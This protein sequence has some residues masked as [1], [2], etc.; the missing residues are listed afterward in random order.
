MRKIATFVYGLFAY[1]LFLGIF[2]YAIGFVGN[3]AV[4]KSID[5]GATG[6]LGAAIAINVALLGLFGLQHS[7][8]ARPGFKKWWTKIVPGAVERSTFVLFTCL[9]LALLYWQWRPI[10]QPVWEVENTVAWW[11]LQVIQLVGWGVVLLS[12]AMIHHFD[13]FG[14]RQVYLYLRGEQYQHL[15]FRTPGLYRYLRHPI[16][17]GFL[18]A[19]WVTPVM[20]AGHLLFAVVT[21]AY[22][23]V[24]LQLEEHD[25]LK[26]HGAQYEQYRRQ[27][28]MLFPGRRRAVEPAPAPARQV[29]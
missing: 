29:A 7:V 21:T 14:M 27:V 2:L 6:P 17:L 8:M 11:I 24:A 26:A 23:L 25:L 12:T 22:I 9:A 10:P 3:F 16:M 20:T 1:L 5:S 28:S 15:G 4:P 19:F 13:L 18:M